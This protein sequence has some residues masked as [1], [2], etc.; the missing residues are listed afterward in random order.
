MDVYT[1]FQH[2]FMFKQL[3]KCILHPFKK[4]NVI[5]W[6]DTFSFLNLWIVA[7]EYIV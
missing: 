3:E 7:L 1:H 2:T 5:L 4:Q 6:L